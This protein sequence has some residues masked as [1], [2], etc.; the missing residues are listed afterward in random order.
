MSTDPA[1][2]S[3][4]TRGN[5]PLTIV[6][7]GAT[8]KKRTRKDA[9]FDHFPEDE[10]MSTDPAPNSDPTQAN[11]LR[12]TAKS[13]ATFKK[14]TR[15]EISPEDEEMEG[16]LPPSRTPGISPTDKYMDGMTRINDLTGRST[17]AETQSGKWF[18]DQLAMKLQTDS[19]GK[20][21]A[22]TGSEGDLPRRKVP[23]RDTSSDADP[24]TAA[25]PTESPRATVAGP[26]IDQYTHLLGIGW[27][28]VGENSNL[29]A[30]AR[31]FGRYIDNH[32]PLIDTEVLSKSESLDSYLC[33]TSQGYFLFKEDLSSGQLVA[34]TWED[35]LANLR[36]S[37]V[38][39]SQTQIFAASSSRTPDTGRESANG[40]GFE[41][42]ESGDMEMD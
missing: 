18:E 23:R 26:T 24:T 8:A 37:P 39:F 30:M 16:T 4:D 29:A 13:S 31:G 34:N 2:N 32:Y 36:C 14:R 19:E 15:E 1:Q 5:P 21:I 20:A 22:M 9:S 42:A 7:P 25:N 27:S 11:P 33:R 3:P 41:V 10:E 28:C 17:T 12:T 38:K 6:S 35:T 40:K